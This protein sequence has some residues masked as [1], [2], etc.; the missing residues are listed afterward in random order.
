MLT[1]VDSR[2][3]AH[4]FVAGFEMASSAVFL[5]KDSNQK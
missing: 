3:F 2:T 4:T 5:S 1:A